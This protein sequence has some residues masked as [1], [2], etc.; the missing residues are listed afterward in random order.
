MLENRDV[1]LQILAT[2]TS[3]MELSFHAVI[4]VQEEELTS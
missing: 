1:Y 2:F 4:I 3:T